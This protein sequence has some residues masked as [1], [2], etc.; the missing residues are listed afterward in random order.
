MATHTAAELYIWANRLEAQMTD[1]LNADD[2]KWLRRQAEKMRSLAA[3][4][5]RAKEHKSR[6]DDTRDVQAPLDATKA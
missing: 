3:K 6:G 1:P 5:E 2:P 4:K